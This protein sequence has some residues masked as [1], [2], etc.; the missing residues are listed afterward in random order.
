LPALVG[1]WRHPSGGVLL[2]SNGDFAVDWQALQRPDLETRLPGQSPRR[3]INMS[4]IGDA[5]LQSDPPIEAVVVYNSNPVAVAP[6]SSRVIEG[7]ARDDLFTVVLDHF[8]TDTADYADILL[9]ATT[10]LEHLD[11]H[12]SYGHRYWVMNQPAIDPCGEALPNSEIFVDSR[13]AWAFTSRAF[14]T[15]IGFWRPRQSI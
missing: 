1:A 4:T 8:R 7:F 13:S 14:S 9:P 2:S 6:D 5:L 12:T 11:I 15:A 3:T 10:Q